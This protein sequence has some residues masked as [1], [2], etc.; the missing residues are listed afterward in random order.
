MISSTHNEGSY[1]NHKCYSCASEVYRTY[2][3]QLM[4]HYYPPKNFT[5]NCW[6]P[7]HLIGTTPCRSA[8]FT[9][10]EDTDEESSPQAIIRGCVDRLLLF[11]MDEDVKDAII[12]YHKTCRWTDR[13]LL[14]LISLTRNSQNVLMCTCSGEICNGGD[15][16]T[17]TDSNSS[18]VLFQFNL[19]IIIV[20]LIL[21]N[22]IWM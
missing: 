22:V 11:G 20:P 18:S 17:R 10:I 15:M 1:T 7:N 2:W 5:D 8:C 21:L 16:R 3:T 9:M 4:H 12:T 14:Q 13:H 19:I 6:S